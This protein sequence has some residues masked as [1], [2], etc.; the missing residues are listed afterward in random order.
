MRTPEQLKERIRMALV[1]DMQNLPSVMKEPENQF[2]QFLEKITNHLH[3]I[4]IDEI[5]FCRKNY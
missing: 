3:E 4:I 2:P 1:E 5:T